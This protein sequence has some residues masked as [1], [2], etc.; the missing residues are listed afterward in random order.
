MCFRGR[1]QGVGAWLA[2][3]RYDTACRGGRNGMGNREF[4][5]AQGHQDRGDLCP[6]GEPGQDGEQRDGE[7]GEEVG[8]KI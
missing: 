7:V 1:H 2:Q 8:N 4:P 6:Q 3:G 5:R